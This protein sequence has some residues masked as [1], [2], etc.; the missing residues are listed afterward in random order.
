[1]EEKSQY[2]SNVKVNKLW[3]RL[4]INWENINN[5]VNILVGINGCGKTTLLNLI[6]DCL[7][8][9]SAVVF[10]FSIKFIKFAVYKTDLYE[11]S[12]QTGGLPPSA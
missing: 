9:V 3:G 1:M 5:D 7:W 10:D 6:S 11:L 2:I 8:P 4:N 12:Y